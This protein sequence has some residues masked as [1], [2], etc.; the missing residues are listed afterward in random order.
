[1]TCIDK[2]QQGLMKK[3]LLSLAHGDTM[4]VVLAPVAFVPVKADYG[5]KIN[6]D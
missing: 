4:F 6:H 1:M 5:I 3:N 2:H